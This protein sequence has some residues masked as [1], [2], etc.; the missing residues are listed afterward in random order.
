LTEAPG[1]GRRGPLDPRLVREIPALRTGLVGFGFAA[2]IGTLCTLAQAV[3][4]ASIVASLFVHHRMS[5]GGDLIGLVVA[6]T[7]KALCAGA[8]E[9]IGHRTSA[10]VRAGMRHRLLS[11]VARLGPLWLSG[12]DRGQVVTAAGPGIESLDGYLTNAVPAVV[13]AAVT[14]LL[15]LA[16][17]GLTDWRS[18][19]IL[20]AVL[21]LVP[22]FL[23]LVGH[24]T[25][26]HMDRQWATLAK[27]SGQFL[28]LL[29]G[30][31]TL[32][33]YGR[34][35]AQVEAVREGT[36]RY[37]RHTLATLRV[38]FLSGLVL[39]LLATLSVALVAVAVG[40]RLDHGTVSLERALIVL[41][42]APEVFAP[43]RAVGA[44]HHATEEARAV[45][46]A[47]MDV[48]DRARRAEIDAG[49]VGGPGGPPPLQADAAGVIARLDDV[50]YAYPGTDQ[51][52]V[53][54]VDMAVRPGELTV[55]VGPSGA[56]K[57]TLL[58][59]LLG[60]AVPSGGRVR[61]GATG[62]ILGTDATG[63]TWRANLAWVPQRPRPTQDDVAGEVRLGDPDLT[64]ADLAAIL[65][66]C[67]APHG[68][69]PAG[70]DGHAP[71]GPPSCRRAAPPTAGQRRARTATPSPP[72]SAVAWRWPAP[73]PA[74][75]GSPGPAGSP[76][77]CSTSPPRTSIPSPRP[78]SSTW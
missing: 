78:W 39:D 75:G 68:P 43:L 28:D 77:S 12:T 30:L 36:D 7:G 73:W 2:G 71:T 48:I 65:T 8:G 6:M 74:P 56:G 60:R 55:L 69:P 32:K 59:L 38:A 31:A 14:P 21:P 26:R 50:S 44:Q 27:L 19:L 29:Q 53:A 42:L 52:S 66:T 23:A 72:G 47:T 61:V 40:L 35:R 13:A 49:P 62:G 3:L 67:G 33:I 58:G 70:A 18:L 34:S 54:H 45:V 46:G 9:W 37:R 5:V 22:V 24:T 76:L 63:E 41:L 51:V 15:V 25:K 20:A 57:S 4:L 1:P 17:I 16:A 11:G 64:A 10:A